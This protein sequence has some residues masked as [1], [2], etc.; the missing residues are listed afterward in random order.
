MNNKSLFFLGFIPEKLKGNSNNSHT[1][2][3]PFLI[4][5]CLGI[6]LCLI[7]GM[8]VF[9][10]TIIQSQGFGTDTSQSFPSAFTSV[11]GTDLANSSQSSFLWTSDVNTGGRG[12]TT[13][14]LFDGVADVGGGFE[15][16]FNTGSI[17]INFNTFL[18]SNGYNITGVNTYAA[19]DTGAGGRSDQEYTLTVIFMDNSTEVITSGTHYNNDVTTASENGEVN[20]WTEV[21]ISDVTGIIAE[22]VKAIRFDFL[23]TA[24]AGGTAT[25]TEFDIIGSPTVN[26]N[27][28]DFTFVHPG[29]GFTTDDLDAIKA[30]LTIEPWKTGYEELLA[31]S[32]SSLSYVMKG[33]YAGVGRSE[34]NGDWS[35]DMRAVHNM[36]RLWYFTGNE[37]YAQKA[38]DILI[39]WATTHT[40]WLPGET[41][42]T[43]GYES[44]RVFEGADLLR[45]AWSGWTE[46]DTDILKAYFRN[47][48]LNPLHLNVPGPL[49]SANQGMSQFAAAINIAVFIDDKN[50]FD[51][52]LYIFRTD[53]SCGL[54]SSLPNGQVGDSGRDAHDQGQIM[55]W[56]RSAETFWQQGVDVYS[57]YDNRILAA[58][59]YLSRANLRVDTPFIQAGTV[60][61]V[62]PIYHYFDSPFGGS[63]HIDTNTIN[64]V[65]S[66]YVTRMGMSAPYLEKY[67]TYT[68][69]QADSFTYLTPSD[70]STATPPAILAGA[71]DVASVTN[72]NN[73]NIGD[74]TGGGVSYNNGTWTVNGGGSSL[75]DNSAPDY[76]FAYLPVDGDAT[77]IA[78]VTSLSGG[79]PQDARAGLVFTEN[80]TDNADMASVIITSPSDIAEMFAFTRGDVARSH[81]ANGSR[82]YPRFSDNDQGL[83]PFPYW[84]KIERIG[85]RVTLYSSPDGAS[86]STSHV[87]DYNIG[88]TAYFGLAVSSHDSNSIATATFSNVRITGGD[89]G[90]AIKAPEVPFAIYASYGGGETPLRWLESFEADSY[91]IWRS[92]QSGGPYNVITE[93]TGTSYIDTDVSLCDQYYYA[94]SA[95]NTMGESELSPED[96]FHFVNT[97]WYEAEDY[98][99]QSGIKTE[100]TRDDLGG[101]NI[102][103]IADGEWTRYDDIRIISADPI[104]KVRAAAYNDVIGDIEV[105]IGSPTGTLIGTVTPIYTGRPQFWATNETTLSVQ[106]GVYDIYLVF[107]NGTGFNINWFDI[108]PTDTSLIAYSDTR[109]EGTGFEFVEGQYKASDGSFDNNVISSLQITEG[110]EVEVFQEDNFTGTSILFQAGDV[111]CFDE[112]NFDNTISSLIVRK[113]TLSIDNPEDTSSFMTFPNPAKQEISLS[114]MIHSVE[115]IDMTGNIVKRYAKETQKI[116]VSG[117]AS[118]VYILKGV[119][120]EGIVLT[121]KVVKE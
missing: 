14:R 74:A 8:P 54:L 62:Y 40:E 37:A 34:N 44:F 26:S 15:A 24:N 112:L 116:N 89:G 19:W 46:S 56:A 105:R 13:E 97:D 31:S 84:L 2:D 59:E 93:Q 109:F 98:D 65:Y 108:I 32:Q 29:I 64:L 53:A 52:L 41:Y 96:Q 36:A 114:R 77:I 17:T 111:I 51:Q 75:W 95:V 92:T 80:L 121:C 48:W 73:D 1:K 66:A 25:Y 104:F 79:S 7:L 68:T 10:Q 67:K 61:D 103:W 16:Q 120:K 30:N 63:Y 9:G 12:D 85:N 6:F 101:R 117:L 86:W 94:V 107:T 60:Y 88:T 21:K 43:M 38:R 23:T 18:N 28:D 4:R 3:M 69:G 58:G 45:G 78:Q 100:E 99:A 39:S 118:G 33:P 57:E 70:N 35:S 50:L 90:E 115:I 5:T 20:V 113:S 42:L 76:H 91:K 72:L 83:P 81:P 87:A 49:R 11:S 106:P 22:G 55:L 27:T 47:V 119:S 102:G 71:A 110:Y 82:Q